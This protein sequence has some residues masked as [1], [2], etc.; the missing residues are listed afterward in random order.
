[1]DLVKNCV[2]LTLNEARDNVV[3]RQKR[4]F[5]LF[6]HNAFFKDRRFGG[7]D[8]CSIMFGER[9]CVRS[10]YVNAA[11]NFTYKMQ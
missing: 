5:C 4:G 2:F 3:F 6:S 1:M 11:D 8:S 7:I 9:N 10:V